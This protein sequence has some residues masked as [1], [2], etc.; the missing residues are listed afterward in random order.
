MLIDWLNKKYGA[1]IEKLEMKRGG[2]GKDAWLSGFLD[3]D[4]SFMVSY[5]KKREI[6]GG[7]GGKK[8]KIENRL[9]IEQRMEDARGGG[10]YEG[11]MREI[12]DLIG[13]NLLIRKQKESGREYYKVGGSSIK[14][15]EIIIKYLD[16]YRLLTSKYMDYRDWR[17]IA[18]LRMEGK[19]YTEEGLAKVEEVRGRINR[20]REEYNW[21]H[22]KGLE[23]FI[24]KD[25][26]SQEEEVPW[27]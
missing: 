4:G 19:H 7:L 3:A 24:D 21:D 15:I 22:L 25:K 17:I 5:T 18:E 2:M 23:K 16:K 13:V 6:E 26:S 27:V 11:V 20:K 14:N 12:A 9:T 8:R 10:N 1:G